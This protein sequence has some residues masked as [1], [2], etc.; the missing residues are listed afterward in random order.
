MYKHLQK[1]LICLLLFAMPYM[2]LSLKA[3][4]TED[5]DSSTTNRFIRANKN[6]SVKE[7]S[8]NSSD[9][10]SFVIQSIS[11]Q[12]ESL[13]DSKFSWTSYLISPVKSVVQRAYGIVDYTIRN[14]QKS[15]IIGVCLA[16]QV[17]AVVADCCC[18]CEDGYLL[19]K[20]A[21]NKSDCNYKCLEYYNVSMYECS[22]FN[23]LKC[24]GL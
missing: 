10:S 15:M 7:K 22:P 14:P 21:Y 16:Y 12:V 5:Y 8:D 17:T 9:I 13:E 20:P 23:G 18:A 11:S 3:M 2:N 6:I 24:W 19:K 4:D 1:S